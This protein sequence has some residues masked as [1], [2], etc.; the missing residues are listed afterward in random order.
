MIAY[1][2]GTDS[3][4]PTVLCAN[5]FAILLPRDSESVLLGPW[6]KGVRS[7]SWISFWSCD[8]GGGFAILN[9]DDTQEPLSKSNR[10]VAQL[11]YNC[12]SNS[13][14]FKVL[15]LRVNFAVDRWM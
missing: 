2:S 11:V 13:G 3:R 6:I 8:L 7:V 9:S 1:H 5:N 12:I 10:I 4:K 15:I 14:S